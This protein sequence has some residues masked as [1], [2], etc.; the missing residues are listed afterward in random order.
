MAF[1]LKPPWRR[2]RVRAACKAG[3]GAHNRGD[4]GPRSGGRPESGR[5]T[6]MAAETEAQASS[7]AE[8]NGLYK[9]ETVEEL[10]ELAKAEAS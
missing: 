6:Q 1:V 5:G 7:W 9:T 10:Y 8:E 2:E 4:P 3:P